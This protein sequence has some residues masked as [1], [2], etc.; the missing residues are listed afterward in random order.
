MSKTCRWCSAEFAPNRD[1]Q[2]FCCTE[3]QQAWNRHDRKRREVQ[4]HEL[5]RANGRSEV[6]KKIVS[7]FKAGKPTTDVRPTTR[8]PQPD[9]MRELRR[10]F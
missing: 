2:E 7:D 4:A 3:H 6:L 1:W 10:R 5:L 9:S 8:E